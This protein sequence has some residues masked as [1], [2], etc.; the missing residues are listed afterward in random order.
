MRSSDRVLFKLHRKYLDVH[1]EGFAIEGLNLVEGEVIDLTEN[2]KTLGLLFQYVYP[3]RQPDLEK[4]EFSV[5]DAL[6]EAAEKY[7]VFP[8]MEICMHRMID[9]IPMHP[10]SVLEY[11]VK[12]GY[13]DIADQAVETAMSKPVES[14]SPRV[15]FLGAV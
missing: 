9:A 1:S 4:I 8:A 6:A 2:S 3:R 14:L 13:P 12:H 5:L 15:D 7:Q 10:F 11:A